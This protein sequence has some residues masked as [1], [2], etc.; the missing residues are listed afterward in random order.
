M[1]TM[2]LRQARFLAVV[3]ATAVLLG[4]LHGAFLVTV[5]Q[6][7]AL[8]TWWGTAL[9]AAFA[10]LICFTVAGAIDRRWSDGSER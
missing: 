6:P 2:R 10:V 1:E 3:L 5:G 8:F 4:L 9:R 7:A